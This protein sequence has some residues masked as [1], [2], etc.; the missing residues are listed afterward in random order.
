MKK[1]I[2]LLFIFILLTGCSKNKEKENNDINI[3]IENIIIEND[4]NQ[5]KDI[6]NEEQKLENN[7]VIVN[8]ETNNNLD[9]ELVDTSNIDSEE[10]VVNYFQDLKIKIKDKLNR[11]TWENVKGSIL[12][13]LNT[14]YGFCFKGEEIG[15]YTL[16]ELSD[17]AKEKILNIVFD[18]DEFIE[19]KSPGYK[20]SFKESYDNLIEKS[21]ESL[22]IIKDK[23]TDIFKKDD[24]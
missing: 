6:Y 21:K 7:N 12:N 13:A 15:G 17:S 23:I 8:D 5:N 3:N 4:N 10:D 18:I 1:V 20:E 2:V 24:E 14:A 16:N 22:G 11:D 9:N 19:S